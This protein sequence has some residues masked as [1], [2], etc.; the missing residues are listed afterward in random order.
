MLSELSGFGFEAKQWH[1]MS[2]TNC[3]LSWHEIGPHS[4]AIVLILTAK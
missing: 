1:K 2:W 4:T 3:W